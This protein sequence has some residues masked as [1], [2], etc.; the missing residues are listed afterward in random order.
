LYIPLADQEQK[1]Q[2][3]KSAKGAKGNREHFACFD[4]FLR[5]ISDP[6]SAFL[7]I[8]LLAKY[9]PTVYNAPSLTKNQLAKGR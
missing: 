8:S 9:R 7:L 2:P 6:T 1:Y 4:P 3:Q 5:Q